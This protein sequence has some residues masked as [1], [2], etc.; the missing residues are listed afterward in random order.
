MTEVKKLANCVIC[1]SDTNFYEYALHPAICTRCTHDSIE[2][3]AKQYY[4]PDKVIDYLFKGESKSEEDKKKYKEHLKSLNV[5][6]NRG[7]HQ[8]SYNEEWLYYFCKDCNRCSG[9]K[10][11]N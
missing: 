9:K 2:K 7:S 3:T 6:G 5:C 10:P 8:W 11:D 4:I 1:D